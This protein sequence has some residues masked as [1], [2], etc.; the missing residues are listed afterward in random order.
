MEM[1]INS[2][3]IRS[4]REKRAWT[5]EHLAN[6]AGLGIR[7]IQ[8][9]EQSGSASPESVKA[10]ASVL[11][12][13]TA[14]IRIGTEPHRLGNGVFSLSRINLATSV[15]ALMLLVGILTIRTSIAGDIRLNYAVTI[16]N[17]DDD[18]N[19][20]KAVKMGNELISEG[21]SVTIL[22]DQWKLEI[23]PTVQQDGSQVM[24]AV[25]V[26]ESVNG[27]YSLRAEPKVVTADTEE[28]AIRSNSPSGNLLSVYLTPSIQ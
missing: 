8:R 4:E 10:L 14:S 16:E 27:D 12:L 2:E 15:V 23:T 25:K 20:L 6:V 13:N 26:F 17:Q 9:I 3:L 24:L 5:Q 18:N 19:A 11:N 21:Q 22:I 1:K 7:T 28:A